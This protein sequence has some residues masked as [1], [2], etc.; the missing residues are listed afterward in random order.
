MLHNSA[1]AGIASVLQAT[2]LGDS[3]GFAFSRFGM[4]N[5]M[6]PRYK[7]IFNDFVPPPFKE[8]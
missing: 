3:E 1:R 7:L 2:Q 8:P 4:M 6:E 5:K